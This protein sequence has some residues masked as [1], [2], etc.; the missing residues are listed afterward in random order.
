MRKTLVIAK[1]EYIAAVRS[2]AFVLSLVMMPIMMFGGLGVQMLIAKRVD[3]KVKRYAVIDRTPGALIAKVLEAAVKVRNEKERFDPKT[4]EP[5]GPPFELVVTA[6]AGE[7]TDAKP[8]QRLELSNKMRRGELD[9]VL[10]IGAK[11][12]EASSAEQ[13]LSSLAQPAQPDKLADDEILRYQT[14]KPANDEFRRWV[15]PVA[16]FAIEQVRFGK[17]QVPWLKVQMLMK[18]VPLVMKGVTTKDPG[19]G[20]IADA[21]EHAVAAPLLVPLV[22]LMLMFAVI[23]VGS[24]PLVQSVIEEKMQRISEVLLGSVSPFQLMLGKLIG[25]AFVSL[26]VV[27]FYLSGGWILAWKYGVAEYLPAS[28]LAWFVLYQTL[29]IFMFGSLFAAV[30]AACT[31]VKETQSMLSPL[32]F[33]VMLPLML[34]GP[35]IKDPNSS[36]ITAVSMLPFT[37]PMLML[38]R[39]SVPPGAPAWQPPVAIL[40]VIACTLACVYVAGRIFRVGLLMQGRAPKFKELVRWALRA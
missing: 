25:M 8:A 11:A 30:G 37:A 27:A 14:T 16:N 1:R 7:G 19:T 26:T 36:F 21:P 23:M 9:G 24:A 40:G 6:P 35:L 28:L 10:E 13:T 33:I 31:D 15:E 38:A 17:A 12:L 3:T 22:L 4:K 34:F 18:R 32:M 5:L 39:Q 20:E 2:R 29:A